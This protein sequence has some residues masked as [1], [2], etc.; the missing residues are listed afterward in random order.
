M[1]TKLFDFGD[2]FGHRK[3]TNDPATPQEVK[4]LSKVLREI[5]PSLERFVRVA[6][7]L[8]VNQ[9]VL[10]IGFIID[11]KPCNFHFKDDFIADTLWVMKNDIPANLPVAERVPKEDLIA[12][13][14]TMLRSIYGNVQDQD[15]LGAVWSP[16]H[17]AAVKLSEI[18][19]RARDRDRKS[20]A[21]AIG[22]LL[23]GYGY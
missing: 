4:D 11:N 14:E 10:D 8:P 1:K 5:Q 6:R 21:K 12:S 2:L 22:R 16:H 17:A 13:V 9:P 15:V 3:P 7:K 23:D 18:L 19:D 20:I